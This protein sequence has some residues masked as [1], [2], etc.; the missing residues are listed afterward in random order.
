MR[1]RGVT[2][3]NWLQSHGAKHAKERWL[4]ELYPWPVLAQV[5]C[6]ESNV[7]RVQRISYDDADYDVTLAWRRWQPAHGAHGTFK[8]RVRVESEGLG[9]H[10]RSFADEFDLCGTPDG[11]FV[12]LFHTKDQEPLERIAKNF[13]GRRWDQIRRQPY[14]SLAVSRFL[15]ASLVAQVVEEAFRGVGLTH[16]PGIRLVGGAAP[17]FAHGSALWIGYRFFSENAYDWARR[18]AGNAQK[19][20]ALYFADTKYQFKTDLP[21]GVAAHSITQFDASN[22]GGRYG[23]LIRV[24]L[25]RLELPEKVDADQ[26][27][28]IIVGRAQAPS[29][30][31][32]EAD[33]HEA[34]DALKHPCNSKSDLRYQLAAAVVLNA[35][36]EDER[37]LGFRG[38]KKFYAFKQRAGE[39]VKW[40]AKANL[41]DVTIWAE[42]G[43]REPLLCVRIDGVDFSFHAIPGTVEFLEADKHTWTGVRLKPIAPLVLAW[44][45]SLR[46]AEALPGQRDVGR[47]ALLCGHGVAHPGADLAH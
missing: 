35:W 15:A 47:D 46:E 14:K 6:D 19:I 38:R 3:D 26:L 13:F 12:T 45:R 1:L 22:L 8:Y 5:D 27:A 23:E 20:V 9:W 16:Y 44:A 43:P 4:R 39:I 41:P 11:A 42:T 17:M 2:F 7:G 32:S 21:S 29:A 36:I 24:L 18:A 34:L 33:V 28:S 40:A 30:S 37:R 31:L 10:A 25:R